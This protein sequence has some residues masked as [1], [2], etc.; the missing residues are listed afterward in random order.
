VI[1]IRVE[2]VVLLLDREDLFAAGDVDEVVQLVLSL[3]DLHE[4]L[5]WTAG[6]R[7]LERDE[8]VAAEKVLVIFFDDE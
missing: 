5:A 4:Y 7:V 2:R 8:A 3:V 6:G 1:D